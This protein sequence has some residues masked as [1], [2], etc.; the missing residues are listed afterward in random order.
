MTTLDREGQTFSGD[1]LL[2]RYI[3]F[4]KLPH[5]LFALPFA[6]LGVLA[7]SRVA[8]VTGRIL[9]LVILAF[10]SARWAAMG[11]NRIVDRQ[12]DARNPRTFNRELP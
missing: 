5:T 9:T 3:N 6:L 12:F 1:S 4:V 11:F 8:P 7:A 10:S 2:T